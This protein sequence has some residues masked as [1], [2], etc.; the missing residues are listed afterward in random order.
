MIDGGFILNYYPHSLASLGKTN[1]IEKSENLVIGQST[2]TIKSQFANLDRFSDTA[3][4][5]F[6]LSSGRR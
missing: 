2:L 5:L 4:V 3:G 6:N 1:F